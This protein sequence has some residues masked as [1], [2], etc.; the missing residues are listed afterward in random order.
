MKNLL[1]KLA[2]EELNSRIQQLHPASNAL[3]GKMNVA[4][5]LAHLQ[6]PLKAALSTQPVPRTFMGRIVSL[7][8]KKKMYDDTPWKQNLPTSPA[9]VFKDE[10]DFDTEKKNLQQKIY[11][12]YTAG[13]AG[14]G[15]FSHPMFGK[16]TKEQWG[17]SAYKHIDHHLTQF[18]V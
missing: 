6:E 5:M 1:H 12:F 17:M 3:W 11:A 16:F 8:F 9:F 18:A 15:N 2:Y 7:F 13:E 10:R 4:Q 14:I